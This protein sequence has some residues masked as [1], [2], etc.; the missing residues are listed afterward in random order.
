MTFYD[1][2]TKWAEGKLGK[3]PRKMLDQA[4]HLLWAVFTLTPIAFKPC[5]WTGLIAGF[6]LALPREFVDQWPIKNW[7]DTVL[8]IIFFSIGG[9]VAGILA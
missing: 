8:D 7:Q 1:K 4:G 2:W 9:M 6:L 3:A 5:W